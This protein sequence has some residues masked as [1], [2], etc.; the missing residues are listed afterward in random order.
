MHVKRQSAATSELKPCNV[1]GENVKIERLCKLHPEMH[2]KIGSMVYFIF[3]HSSKVCIWGL[4]TWGRQAGE[5]T[6]G[7]GCIALDGLSF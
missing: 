3:I 2:F 7:G 6:F 1:C 5:G 4:V